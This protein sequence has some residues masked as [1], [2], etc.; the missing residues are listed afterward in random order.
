MDRGSWPSFTINMNGLVLEGLQYRTPRTGPV[1][2]LAGYVPWHPPSPVHLYISFCFLV[3]FPFSLLRPWHF[4]SARLSI[5]PPSSDC[6]WCFD[7]QRLQHPQGARWWLRYLDF[8]KIQT[9]H[10]R[11]FLDSPVEW[12]LGT[13]CSNNSSVGCGWTVGASPLTQVETRLHCPSP[14]D[15]TRKKRWKTTASTTSQN[16]GGRWC[17]PVPINPQPWSFWGLVS[18]FSG[19]ETNGA[20]LLSPLPIYA[21][22]I[23]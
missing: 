21:K 20:I 14:T 8:L 7:Q 4:S 22:Q 12:I 19:G 1:S 13:S 11:H 3:K 15:E 17:K 18:S 10:G 16:S 23:P 5:N 2:L 9:A 6:L